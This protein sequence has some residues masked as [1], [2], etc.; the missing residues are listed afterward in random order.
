LKALTSIAIFVTIITTA[1]AGWFR[2]DSPAVQ[3][4][5]GIC[6][7]GPQNDLVIVVGESGTILRS[8]EA[9]QELAPSGTT[10]D[11]IAVSFADYGVGVA[12]GTR[13]TI[14]KSTNGGWNWTTVTTQPGFT[15]YD[16][17]QLDP[18]IGIAV[19]DSGGLSAR[20]TSTDDGWQSWHTIHLDLARG[21]SPDEGTLLSVSLFSPDSSSVCAAL[22]DGRSRLYSTTDGWEST[23]QPIPFEHVLHK[24]R[25]VS[26]ART[27]L[28]GENGQIYRG[29]GGGFP[30]GWTQTLTAGHADYFAL[31]ARASGP[32]WAA[33]AQGQISVSR[34][35]GWLWDNQNSGTDER[36]NGILAVNDSVVYAVG[37]H[38]IILKTLDAGGLY[39]QNPGVFNIVSPPAGT[40]VPRADVEFVWTRSV[41]PLGHRV[42]YAVSIVMDSVE[43]PYMV[44]D[45]SMIFNF[46]NIHEFR[47]RR[48]TTFLF[49]QAL[50]SLEGATEAENS[51][52]VFTLDAELST[53]NPT[54]LPGSVQLEIYPNPFNAATTIRY[55]LEQFGF[56]NLSIYDLNGRLVR[57]LYSGIQ[58]GGIHSLNFEANDQS[59]GVYVAQLMTAQSSRREKMVIIK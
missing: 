8:Q 9:F 34:E 15:Y 57:T 5:R 54:P 27:F 22:P 49:V 1:Q 16:V 17:H 56:V 42:T 25:Y 7:V 24:V 11:L 39:T 28:A 40:L 33:G 26:L 35:S 21:P 19:G 36:L 4:L 55:E 3:D 2:V 13:G 53:A 20:I 44:D 37:E 48:I 32:L 46:A 38:G 43:L 23:W 12:V 45:T 10:E 6:A 47:D 51:P 14:L 58:S 31:T 41:H 52:L 30:Q 29:Y 18:F 59:S 50:D